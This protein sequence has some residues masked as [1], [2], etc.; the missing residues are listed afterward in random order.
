MKCV[1]ELGTADDVLWKQDLTSPWG[2]VRCGE[3]KTC[4][5]NK[6]HLYN[7]C[8]MLDQRRRRW[9]DVVGMLYKCFVFAGHKN[10]TIMFKNDDI[11]F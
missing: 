4:S 10:V 8:T 6:T 5:A 9:A 11:Y 7:I 2:K 3:L 1:W